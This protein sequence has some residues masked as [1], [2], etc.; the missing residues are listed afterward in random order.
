MVKYRYVRVPIK[1]KRRKTVSRQSEQSYGLFSGSDLNFMQGSAGTIDYGFGSD[2]KSS[3]G[4]PIGSIDYGFGEEPK[5]R[6]ARQELRELKAEDALYKYKSQKR[7]E[8]IGQIKNTASYVGAGISRFGSGVKKGAD[9]VS[10]KVR[11]TVPR[12]GS[13]YGKSWTGKPKQK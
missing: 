4:S 6:S 13:I 9:F 5:R 2:S 8:T 10:S 1:T 7:A 11:G 3:R 12:Y